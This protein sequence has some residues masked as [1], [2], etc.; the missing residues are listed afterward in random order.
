VRT[1]AR[2]HPEED[3]DAR[4]PLVDEAVAAC[5]A[6]GLVDDAAFAA[7]RTATLRRRGWPERR[8]RMAL[9]QKGVATPLV[10]A[11]IAADDGDDASAAHRFAAR[12]RLGPW[13]GGNRAEKRDKDIAAMMRA[14]FS[15]TLARQA[16]DSETPECS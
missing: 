4:L 14:G 3:I 16:I 7:G 5:I 1:W 8:I 11:A 6:A 2:A 10:D 13:R 15:L 9:R 12:R